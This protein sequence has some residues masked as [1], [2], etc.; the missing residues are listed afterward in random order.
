MVLLSDMNEAIYLLAAVPIFISSIYSLYHV[1]TK[2]ERRHHA[3]HIVII[4]LSASIAWLM[5]VVLKEQI[6]HPRPDLTY[7]LFIPSDPYSFPSGHATFMFGLAFAMY[8]FDKHAG[9]M[10]FSLACITGVARVLSGVHY[11]YDI[12]GGCILGAGVASII[13]SLAKQFLK[14]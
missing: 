10:L 12:V 7:A 1:V 2:H 11:W 4:A 8:S 9:K 6:A 14:K 3:Q 5:S 13:V